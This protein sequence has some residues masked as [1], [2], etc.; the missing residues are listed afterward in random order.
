MEN[1]QIIISWKED[2]SIEVLYTNI[3]LSMMRDAI[4]ALVYHTTNK[5]TGND[6]EDA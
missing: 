4:N 2:A 1:S 6:K 3:N 5:A